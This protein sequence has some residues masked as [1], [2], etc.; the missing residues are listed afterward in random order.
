MTN[1]LGDGGVRADRAPLSDLPKHHR[2][3][4][5][6]TLS[7]SRRA[8]PDRGQ[9]GAVRDKGARLG[10][11]RR[12]EH[13]GRVHRGRLRPAPRGL[14]PEQPARRELLRAGA[15]ANDARRAATTT[16]HAA[17]PPRIRALSDLVL[18]AHVGLLPLPAAAG[19]A[20]PRA[21]RRRD[22]L[23]ARARLADVRRSCS[24][25]GARRTRSSIVAHVC[26]P[27]LCDDNLSG[28]SVATLL[29][30]D[31]MAGDR[32]R[33]APFGSCSLQARSG[34]SHGSPATRSRVAQDHGAGLTLTCLGDAHPFTFKRT[35]AGDTSGRSCGRARARH[36]RPSA[37]DRRLLPVRVRRAPLQLARV[38]RARGLAHARTPRPVPRVPHLRATTSTSSAPNGWRESFDVLAQVVTV[39]DRR[40]AHAQHGTVR[41]AA[42]RTRG[43]YGAL[44][45]TP[46]PTRNS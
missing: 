13:R 5:R 37:P 20:R 21:I 3:R 18:R 19:G 30:R 14:R 28:I 12:V 15:D 24:C 11:P 44:G 45:G 46:S 23:D 10:D 29:A 22:R 31:L 39:L 16:P 43:L 9:R 26:H 35:L 2:Q 6:Q 40:P 1:S 27:S 4:V 38:P 8:H 32:R 25:R 36:L 7:I 34:R 41:R 33:D 17:R 42:A